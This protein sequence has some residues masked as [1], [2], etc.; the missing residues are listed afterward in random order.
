MVR[1]AMPSLRITPLAGIHDAN[2][3]WGVLQHMPTSMV[4]NVACN[5]N[6]LFYDRNTQKYKSVTDG[7]YF[8]LADALYE[9]D[10][11]FI[12][13]CWNN[14]M[15]NND[16]KPCGVIVIWSDQRLDKEISAF[17]KSRRTPSYRI[18]ADLMYAGAPLYNIARIEDIGELNGP[19]LIINPDLLPEEEFNAIKNY[20]NGEIFSIGENI[21]TTPDIAENNRFGGMKFGCE[22][23]RADTELID[24][25]QEYE[26]DPKH[27]LEKCNM[28]WTHPLDYKPVSDVFYKKCAD[29]INQ[30]CHF[31]EITRYAESCQMI[32]NKTDDK[33]YRVVLSNDEYYYTHP[34][35]DMKAEIESVKCLTKYDGF[36]LSPVGT[37]FQCRIAGRGADVFDV[38][39]K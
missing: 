22:S 14:G 24:N 9:S 10:W 18:M 7:P 19:L 15:I 35:V 38:V 17:I 5:L 13:S 39:L 33:H 36:Q 27:S 26:F 3:Q 16:T 30:K 25:S 29:F 1:A 37:T 32:V 12:R 23:S 6:T 20:T 34:M 8:C 21:N 11:N 4:R 28:L 31:P 2:E